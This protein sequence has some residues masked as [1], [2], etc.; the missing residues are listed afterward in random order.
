VLQETAFRK[1]NVEDIPLMAQW[2]QTPLVYEFFNGTPSS[3]E[4]V[5]QKYL[6]RIKGEHPVKPFIFHYQDVTAGYLQYYPITN[7]ETAD[8]PK[9][10]KS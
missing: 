2:L 10:T 8:L 6:P 7:E 4:A 5:R 3:L 9:M 1:M